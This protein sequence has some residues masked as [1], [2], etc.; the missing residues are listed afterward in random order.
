MNR[1]AT[2]GEAVAEQIRR[3]GGEAAAIACDVTDAES[4][5]AA[6]AAVR[7]KYG[8]C[9]ILINGA[10]GNQASANTTNEIFRPEDL[11]NPEVTTFFDLSLTG[12]RG[13]LDL[14]FTG[15]LI[16]TQVLPRK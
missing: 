1:T 6:E 3:D 5:K 15:A 13:V 4:V 2:K 7:E 11:E 12:V 10:G 16:P 14:N 9:D 8:P